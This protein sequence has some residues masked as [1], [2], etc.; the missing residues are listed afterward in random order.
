MFKVSSTTS[1]AKLGA[2]ILYTIKES[3]REVALRAIGAAA[4]NRAVKGIARAAVISS[5]SGH[6]LAFVP[7]YTQAKV[8]GEAY[9]AM[10]FR[11][12]RKGDEDR[13]AG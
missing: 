12:F 6:R 4:V 10:S 11:I 13:A 2:A 3:G 1:P 7:G 9:T 5:H 8:N